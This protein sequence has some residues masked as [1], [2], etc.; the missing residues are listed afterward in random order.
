MQEFQILLKIMQII[1]WELTNY[2]PSYKYPF[3]QN[4][5]LKILNG[6]QCPKIKTHINPSGGSSIVDYIITN[7]NHINNG[8]NID[9]KMEIFNHLLDSDHYP[10]YANIKFKYNDNNLRANN[11]EI[12]V[13]DIISNIVAITFN[14]IGQLATH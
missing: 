2:I 13:H 11:T 8:I 1:K 7:N 4:N 6:E 14:H 5:D 10:I 3:L 9:I 12:V